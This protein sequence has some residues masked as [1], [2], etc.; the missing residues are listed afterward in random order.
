MEEFKAVIG[1]MQGEELR[2]LALRDVEAAQREGQAKAI[3]IIGTILGLM[4]AGAAGWSVQRDLTA[5][6]AADEHL[7]QMDGRYRDFLE[8]APDAMV[9]VD[10]AGDIV[11]L[12]LQAEKQFGYSRDEFVGQ[13]VT[14]IIPEGFAERLL[15]DD[16]RTA[17]DALAQQIGTGIELTGRRKDGREFPIEMML[18]PFGKSRRAPW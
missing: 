6:R 4:I 11:L 12:N 10:P 15:A 7:A 1:K 18:S 3:L 5:R 8:A 14:N 17:A 16:T 9:V 2:L 13:K